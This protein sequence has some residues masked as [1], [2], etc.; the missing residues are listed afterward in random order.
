MIHENVQGGATRRTGSAVLEL[1][2]ISGRLWGVA[3]G[4]AWFMSVFIAASLLQ[5]LINLDASRTFQ[6]KGHELD[7][8]RG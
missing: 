4:L 5:A 8:D 6:N 1:T 2:L 3:R 7:Q